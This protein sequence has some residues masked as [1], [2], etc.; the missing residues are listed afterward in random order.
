[1]RTALTFD[2]SFNAT[3][4]SVL[5]V[6]VPIIEN[7]TQIQDHTIEVLNSGLVVV[8]AYISWCL[9]VVSFGFAQ[10]SLIHFGKER[11]EQNAP[12][13]AVQEVPVSH[14]LCSGCCIIVT[15]LNSGSV[16]LSFSLDI[17]LSLNKTYEEAVQGIFDTTEANFTTY[18]QVWLIY[19]AYKEAQVTYE[20]LQI[21]MLVTKEL[22]PNSVELMVFNWSEPVIIQVVVP[23]VPDP[24]RNTSVTHVKHILDIDEKGT[25][26]TVVELN[27]TWSRPFVR[28]GTLESYDL[29]AGL[30]GL[31]SREQLD[32]MQLRNILVK[33]TRKVHYH[34]FSYFVSIHTGK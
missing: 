8:T 23:E 12:V 11:L 20:S 16:I 15:C 28:V 29:Y 13:Q 22:N 3:D 17:Q 30:R 32:D 25:I 19:R 18:L 34:D 27:V 9:P 26:V 6:P 4:I 14:L 33:W 7:V 5:S 2:Y 21:R 24:I 1:M 10:T 31:T